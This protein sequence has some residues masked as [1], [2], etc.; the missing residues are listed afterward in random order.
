MYVEHKEPFDRTV[1]SCPCCGSDDLNKECL[2]EHSKNGCLLCFV[3][4]FICDQCGCKWRN[5]QEVP[6]ES[7]C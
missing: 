2:Q 3:L 6:K 4:F 5:G 7:E 1:Q